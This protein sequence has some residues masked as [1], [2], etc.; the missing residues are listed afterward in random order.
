[1][2]WHLSETELA[3]SDVRLF[4]LRSLALED[5][6]KVNWKPDRFDEKTESI[7]LRKDKYRVA[8]KVDEVEETT[9]FSVGADAEKVSR[10]IESYAG[11]GIA[12]RYVCAMSERVSIL[13][14]TIK[15]KNLVNLSG[16]DKL[17]TTATRKEI[18]AREYEALRNEVGFIT[19]EP[20]SGGAKRRNP[21][22]LLPF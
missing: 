8:I 22:G 1:M 11:Q 21:D 2:I 16:H 14:R 7:I 12:F 18:A 20:S 10:L 9:E 6:F 17:A 3:Q 15:K 5:F 19:D 4:L 13:A